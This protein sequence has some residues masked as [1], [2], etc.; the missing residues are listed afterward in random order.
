[1][2]K[3]DRHYMSK[4]PEY[5][6]WRGI[7]A[8]CNNPRCPAYKNYGGRGITTPEHWREFSGFIADVGLRPAGLTLERKDNNAGYSKENCV[9]AT[10]VAQHNNTRTNVFLT[11]RGD[12]KTIAQ[13]SVELSVPR[14][15]IYKRISYGWTAERALTEPH[16]D[17]KTI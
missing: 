12:T 16:R 17:D 4:S 1:M 15:R 13:W 5:G 14:H 7:L 9:W 3:Y 10:T 8:R 6:I 2:A 11:L